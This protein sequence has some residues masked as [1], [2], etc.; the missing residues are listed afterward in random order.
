MGG[1][2]EMQRR[3]SS[4]HTLREKLRSLRV[5]GRGLPEEG[6]HCGTMTSRLHPEN[7]E[8]T[9]HVEGRGALLGKGVVVVEQYRNYTKEWARA[10]GTFPLEES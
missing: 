7:G 1:V 6:N 5:V 9:L 8:R 4:A 10:T 3:Q 2:A